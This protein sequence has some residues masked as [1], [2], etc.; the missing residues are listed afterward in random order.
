MDRSH[1]HT[2]VSTRWLSLQPTSE[3]SCLLGVIRS[4]AVITLGSYQF[5]QR[6]GGYSVRTVKGTIS[7]VDDAISTVKDIQL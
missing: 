6:G 4:K 1:S 7:V 2:P 5:V 3:G